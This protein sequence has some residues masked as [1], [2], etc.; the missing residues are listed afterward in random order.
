M[1]VCPPDSGDEAFETV[2]VPAQHPLVRIQTELREEFKNGER[3][4]VQDHGTWDGRWSMPS[5][6]TWQAVERCNRLWPKGSQDMES[7]V[8]SVNEVNVLL[9]ARKEYKWRSMTEEQK[10]L[11][12]EAT[13]NGWKAWVENDAIEVLSPEEV[14][15]VKARLRRDGEM[16]KILQPRFVF[17]D[18][19]DGLRT[20][21]NPM[22]LKPSARLVVP[23][24]QDTS[25]YTIRKDAPTASRVMQHVLFA[26]TASYYADGWRLMSADVKSAFLKGDPYIE[27]GEGGR[28]LFI[29]NVRSSGDEPMLPFGVGGLA[30][31]KKGVF[32]LADAPR[33]WYLRLH[34]ALSERGWERS[35]MDFACWLL[36]NESRTKLEGMVLSHVDDLLLG[37]T[38]KAKEQIADLGRELGFGSVEEGSFVY[39]GKKISQLDDGT[40]RVSM[41]EY[42]KNIQTVPIAT[43]RKMKPE[44]ELLPSERRQLRA[45]LGSLQWLVAQVRLDFGFQLSTLQS[46]KPIVATLMKANALVRKF[47]QMPDFALMFRPMCLKNAGIMVVTDAALGNVKP[48]GSVG[49]DAPPMEKTHSQ[50]SYFALLADEKLMKGEEGQ[51]AILDGRSHRISRVCRSTF[52]SELLGT[53]EA[54]DIGQYCRG[55]WA[56]TLG[57]DMRQKNVDESL[58]AVGLTVVTDAKDV[59]DKGSSDTP[60]YGSQKALAFTVAWI[61]DILRR[62]RTN[63]RWTST[64]NLF[65]DCG[66]K[67]MDQSHMQKILMSGRW[68][69]KYRPALV[70]QTVKKVKKSPATDGEQLMVGTPMSSEDD[71]YN[72][73]HQ[74]GEKPGW[75]FKDNLAVNVSRSARSYRTPEP[76][77][78]AEKFPLRSSYGRF[79]HPSG[80]SEWRT[81]ETKVDLQ[82]LE[83]KK[84]LIGECAGILVSIFHPRPQSDQQ[85][86]R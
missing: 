52:A 59:Y 11:F 69:V 21:D 51:F 36:W 41:E 23:G 9:A 7:F 13:I 82:K 12:K 73:L 17:T 29:Q 65:V 57:Y 27:G 6:S 43:A 42:H 1:P 24:Y 56:C 3:L 22:E 8:I 66:T 16:T 15:S 50:A 71:I 28:E 37:G 19:N 25:A 55:I 84:A 32:G 5:R 85:K 31:I 62:P 61:R 86:D 44:A 38:A 48:D 60:T 18:K 80:H 67:D 46:E 78:S 10:R 47:K 58:N 54:F 81:L 83:R 34:R 63:L 26:L 4:Q 53:E 74:L 33:Q 77:F 64:E 72:Y 76:R 30:R 2:N 35:A 79:D 70:K 68:S 49:F 39:C 14:A 75:H 40:I 20:L 45:I